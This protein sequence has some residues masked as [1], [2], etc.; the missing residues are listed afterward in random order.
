MLKSRRILVIMVLAG[1]AVPALPVA[2]E[3]QDPNDRS[4]LSIHGYLSLAF[5]ISD[6]HQYRGVTDDGTTELRNAA[7]QLRYALTKKDEFVFQISNESVGESPTNELRDPVELD[8]VFYHRQ[9]SDNTTLRLG[10]VPLPIGIYNEIKDVGTLLPFYRPAG[11]FYGEGTWTSD[12]VDGLVLSHTLAPD[13]EWH[14]H[15]EAY[16]GSWDRIEQDGNTLSVGVADIDNGAGFYLW[17]NTPHPGVRFGVGANRFDASGGVYLPPGVEDEE[18]TR[19]ASFEAA[20]DR[21]TFRSEYSRRTFTGGNWQAFYVELTVRL[22]PK[23][24]LMG[25]YDLGHLHYAIPFFAT[26]DD[27]MEEAVGVGVNYAFR[28]DLVFKAEHHWVEGYGQIEDQTV[29]FFF[30]EPLETNYLLLSL[31]THF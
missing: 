12:T 28:D 11:N 17:L 13:A 5:G 27:D 20:F 9:L 22:S 15:L 21:V 4:K 10:R 19:Y 2:A 16:Y 18:K 31:S 26:F 14:L 23:L 29:N 30:D 24:Q 6:G 7:I 3:D 1:A 25:I 8:W